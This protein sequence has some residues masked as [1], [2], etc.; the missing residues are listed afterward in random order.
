MVSAGSDGAQAAVA[1][2]NFVKTGFGF[3]SGRWTQFA[4]RERPDWLK[5]V[6]VALLVGVL[7][8]VLGAFGTYSAFTLSGRYLFWITMA[9]TGLLSLLAAEALLGS[10]LRTLPEARTAV[11]AAASAVPMT[12]FVTWVFSLVQPGRTFPPSR[13]LPLY[14][15]VALV[16]LILAAVV[17]RT[18]ITEKGVQPPPAS[19]LPKE[20]GADVIALEAEDHYLRVHRANGSTLVLMRLADAVAADGGQQGLQVHRSWWV[21]R[22]AVQRVEAARLHL[23]NGLLVPVGRTFAAQVRSAFSRR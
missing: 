21:S 1:R 2:C 20:L 22:D 16:Q 15:C 14:L 18:K 3:A 5:R 12:F 11:L 8:G 17:T 10:R 13:L 4:K 6:G 9:V 19:R 23:S 7:L